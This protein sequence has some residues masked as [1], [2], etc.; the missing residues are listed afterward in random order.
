MPMIYKDQ[1]I[2]KH[3]PFASP[4]SIEDATVS[5]HEVCGFMQVYCGRLSRCDMLV[6]KTSHDHLKIT[7]SISHACMQQL[8]PDQNEKSTFYLL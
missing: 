4:V 7:C 8:L 1:I 6:D 3:L 2:L 5:L